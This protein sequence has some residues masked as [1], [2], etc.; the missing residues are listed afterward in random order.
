MLRVARDSLVGHHSEGTLGSWKTQLE[1]EKPHRSFLLSLLGAEA[2]VNRVAWFL[3]R[4]GRRQGSKLPLLSG[5]GAA[6]M[7]ISQLGLQKS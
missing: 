1:E 7:S 4:E 6:A 2:A 3:R 5:A